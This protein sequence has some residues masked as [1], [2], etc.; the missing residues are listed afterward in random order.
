MGQPGTTSSAS[1]VA[2]TRARHGG[3]TDTV[4]D[5]FRYHGIWAPGVRLFRSI[6]FRAKALVITAGFALPIAVLAYSYFTDKAAA[7]EFSASERL[8]VEYLRAAAPVLQALQQQRLAA[9]QAA[10]S[11]GSSAAAEE[12]AARVATALTGLARAEATAGVSLSTGKAHADLLGKLKNLPAPGAAQSDIVALLD[13]HNDAI[14]AAMTLVTTA[15]DNSNLTLDPDIDTYY[16]MDASTA[17]LPGLAEAVSRVQAMAAAASGRPEIDAKLQRPMNDQALIASLMDQ[18]WAGDVG[19]VLPLHPDV[20][21]AFQVQAVRKALAELLQA[22]GSAS[23]VGRLPATA[24]EFNPRLYTV[25][26]KTADKLDQLIAARV[27]RLESARNMTTL[28]LL[29]SLVAVLYLFLSFQKVLDGGLREVAFHIESMRDGDLTTSP[30]AWGADEAASLMNTVVAMQVSL[31]RIVSHVRGASDNIVHAS[32]Q[33]ASG[34]MDLSSRTEHAAANLEQS[35]SAMEQISATVKQTADAALKAAEIARRN[36]EAAARGGE[37]IGTMVT[38][39]DG[40]HASSQRIGDIVGT[41]DAIAFQT[42]ILALNA[43]VEA[44]RAGDSGRG[45]AVV[46]S[47]VRGLAMR[48]AAAAREIK[49]LIHS[50]VAQV[51]SGTDV[52]RQAGSAIA[53]IVAQAGRVDELM[54][55]ISTSAREQASGVQQTTLAVHDMDSATQQNAALVEQTAAAAASLQEQAGSLAAE[56]ARFK[57]A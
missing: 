24:A 2:S 49:Q 6:G 30:S 35:A 53:E 12:A 50:S 10:V 4:S 38:T 32:D 9:V 19:K 40:I 43:A 56:V 26:G 55:A 37:V 39:M 31:R 41:I 25:L 54:A 29:L 5:F 57:L 21:E 44:A 52:A 23:D 1:G 11:P 36:S 34:S 33:I 48:S 42:N 3:S 18:R 15:T 14:G 16:L 7:I 17:A 46:A 45:F 27:A 51:T 28:V 20:N 8:G 22:A 13:A 47:E